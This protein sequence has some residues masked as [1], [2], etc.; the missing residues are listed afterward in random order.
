[1]FL[2]FFAKILNFRKCCQKFAECL[3]NF[4]QFFF[5]WDFR[6]CSISLSENCCISGIR[7]AV[8][9]KVQGTVKVR[10]FKKVRNLNSTRILI[11]NPGSRS[12]WT[13]RRTPPPRRP[14]SAGCSRGCRRRRLRAGRYR[15]RPSTGTSPPTVTRDSRDSAVANISVLSPTY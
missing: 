11:C 4:D 9:S 13:C 12:P 5:F 15:S 14:T 2:L 6:K 8:S 7:H 3:L 1:M 10:K